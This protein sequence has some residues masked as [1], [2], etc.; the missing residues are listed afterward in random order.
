MYIIQKYWSEKKIIKAHHKSANSKC[1]EQIK[2]RYQ[3]AAFKA[4]I[5][6][7]QASR[8]MIVAFSLNCGHSTSCS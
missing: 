5:Y 1:S 6:I 4:E 3:C 7:V 2:C 8:N